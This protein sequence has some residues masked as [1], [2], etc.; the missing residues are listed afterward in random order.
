MVETLFRSPVNIQKT[1][2]ITSVMQENQVE[3]D[4]AFII[5]VFLRRMEDYS[6]V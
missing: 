3:F 6:A 4:R 1:V 5:V 2:K